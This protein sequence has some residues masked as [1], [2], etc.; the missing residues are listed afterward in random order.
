MLLKKFTKLQSKPV[1][2]EEN[3]TTSLF[4]N[5]FIYKTEAKQTKY[6]YNGIHNSVTRKNFR[7]HKRGPVQS[8]SKFLI[9]FVN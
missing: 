7:L 9:H 5:M 2:N 6:F 3:I 4:L 8:L 1:P